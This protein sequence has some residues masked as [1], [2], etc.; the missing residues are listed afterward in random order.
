MEKVFNKWYGKLSRMALVM[1]LVLSLE[2]T[3]SGLGDPN[4]AFKG[5][6]VIVL[7]S[8][9]LIGIVLFLASWQRK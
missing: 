9:G 1:P 7:L 8:W 3:A 4:W 6:L 5:L 2:G